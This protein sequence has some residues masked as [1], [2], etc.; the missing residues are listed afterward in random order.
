MKCFHSSNFCFLLYL[1][2]SISQEKINCDV[3]SRIFSTI[4]WIMFMSNVRKLQDVRIYSMVPV[5]DTKP[6]VTEWIQDQVHEEPVLMLLTI[7]G[8][9]EHMGF[10]VSQQRWLFHS[11]FSMFVET[12]KSLANLSG[13][14]SAQ[15]EKLYFAVSS[16]QYQVLVTRSRRRPSHTSSGSD[17]AF[18]KS[19]ILFCI[20]L[21]LGLARTMPCLSQ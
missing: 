8:G 17:L 12:Q 11:K 9:L 2:V 20:K 4:N 3:N 10:R 16:C 1:L 14:P 7:W 19:T 18:S 15:L 5:T 13:W 21:M 6:G